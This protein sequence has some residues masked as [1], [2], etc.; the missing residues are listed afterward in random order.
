M[1]LFIIGFLIGTFSGIVIMC[2]V[3]VYKEKE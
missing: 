2:L 1:G 3:Q